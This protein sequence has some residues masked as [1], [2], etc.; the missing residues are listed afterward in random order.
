MST[1][2]S[3]QIFKIL[4]MD[5]ANS[6]GIKWQITVAVSAWMLFQNIAFSPQIPYYKS[7][8]YTRTPSTTNRP[9]QP[10]QNF[11]ILATG[12]AKSNIIKWQLTVAVSGSSKYHIF[13]HKCCTLNKVNILEHN[14]QY[15]QQNHL[16]RIGNGINGLCKVASEQLHTATTCKSTYGGIAKAE[17][18]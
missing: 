4:A 7:Q 6:N 1:K 18:K 8:G 2:L 10:V 5:C 15:I 13:N 16:F 17:R 14:A 12:N 9:K 3:L 11:G